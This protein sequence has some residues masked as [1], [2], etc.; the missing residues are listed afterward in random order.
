M[1]IGIIGF[2]IMGEG[3]SLYLCCFE[4]IKK[5]YIKTGKTKKF[6]K[7]IFLKK[8]KINCRFLKKNFRQRGDL[9]E[10][11]VPRE[12]ARPAQARP[13]YARGQC[14]LPPTRPRAMATAQRAGQ[15]VGIQDR[16]AHLGP[17]RDDAGRPAHQ[18]G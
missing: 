17:R 7:N 11:G 13:H 6:D 1:N 16:R 8:L 18:Q 2:G 12:V 9:T 14:P 10:S 3:L 4:H 15:R 5:I